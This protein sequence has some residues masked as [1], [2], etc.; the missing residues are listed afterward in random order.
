MLTGLPNLE[1][2]HLNIVQKSQKIDGHLVLNTKAS[3]RIEGG[4]RGSQVSF[5]FQDAEGTTL[6]FVG[7]A[8]ANK[9]HG[10][11]KQIPN[12]VVTATRAQ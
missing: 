3:Q 11:V 4:L 2:S 7:E 6:S 12:S 8:G 5:D 1:N 9:I 10:T